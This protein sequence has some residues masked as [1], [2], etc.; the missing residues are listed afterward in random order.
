M[1][2]LSKKFG[3]TPSE[4]EFSVGTEEKT[5]WKEHMSDGQGNKSDEKRSSSGGK[6]F[7]L[8]MMETL[9]SSVIVILVIYSTVAFP[10]MVVGSSMEPNF[11]TGERILVEKV[12]RYFKPYERG[13]IVVLHPPGNDSI[14]YIKR[15]VGM[16]GDVVKIFDCKV[17]IKSGEESFLYDEEYLADGMCTSGGSRLKEGRSFKIEDDNYFV[18]GDN[19]EKSL[20]SRSFGVVAKERILGKV[21]YR[22]WPLPKVGFINVDSKN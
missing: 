10:E 6:G 12:T 3:P 18:L 8:E 14:D 15:I 1:P 13:D 7:V 20:D 16:P 19:R 11:Y 5:G 17:Y 21:I 2:L 4:L 22:F 9:V